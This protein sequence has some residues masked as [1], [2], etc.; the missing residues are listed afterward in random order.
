MAQMPIQLYSGRADRYAPGAPPARPAGIPGAAYLVDRGGIPGGPLRPGAVDQAQFKALLEASQAQSTAAPLRE[1]GPRIPTLSPAQFAALGAV[2]EPA[3]HAQAASAPAIDM[4]AGYML[5]PAPTATPVA[6]NPAAEPAATSDTT[7]PAAATAQASA[8]RHGPIPRSRMGADGVWELP[9]LPD[10]DE[11]EMLRGQ[12]WRVVEDPQA[13][14][15]FLGPDGE[16]GWD[17]F[18]DLINPFQHIPFLNIAYRAVTGDEIHGA[19][20][21]VDFAFGPLAGASTALDL[22]V[23]SV[24][25]KSM[26]DNA[27]AALFGEEAEPD[28]ETAAR[29]DT[30]AGGTQLADASGIRRGSNR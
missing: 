15:L 27:V 22:A 21:M 2:E 29:F 14:D 1:S 18:V 4:S 23:Q 10:K 12:K 9:R 7:E 17:D 8:D 24:T 3:G 16:F 26:V 5:D 13:R 30:A 11:R 6:T 28:A 20:R 25:G 19:A